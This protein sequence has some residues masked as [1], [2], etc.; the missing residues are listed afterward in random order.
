MTATNYGDGIIAAGDLTVDH[1]GKTFRWRK[2]DVVRD[3]AVI[4][5]GELRQIS[6]DLTGTVIV[7]GVMGEREESFEHDEPLATFPRGDYADIMRLLNATETW[8]GNR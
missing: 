1:I 2:V 3:I 7:Y 8:E 5:T 4:T 6:H